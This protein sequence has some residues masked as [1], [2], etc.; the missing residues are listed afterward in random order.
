MISA[1]RTGLA[2]ALRSLKVRVT[3]GVVVALVVGIGTIAT[4]LVNRAE[5]DTLRD[6]RQRELSDAAR[7]ADQVSNNVVGLQR[8]LEA[9]ARRLDAATLADP[10]EL[11][12]LIRERPLLLLRF[13]SVFVTGRDGQVRVLADASGVQH[14]VLN[15]AD[16][17]YFRRTLTERRPIVSEPIT[18]RVNGQLI[19]ILTYPVTGANGI[20]AVLSGSLRLSSRDLLSGLMDVQESDVDALTVLTDAEGRV[21][22]HPDRARVMHSLADEPR[23]AAA[24]AAWVAQGSPM[25]PT[26]VAL[27]QPGEMVSAA[28]AAGTNWMAWR[29]RSESELLAPLRAARREAVVWAAGLIALIS[30]AMFVFLWRELR[31]LVLLERRAQHLFDGQ[32]DADAAW[33]DAGGEIGRLGRVLR[34]VGAERAQ[35][36]AFNTQVLRKLGSVMSAA[37]IGIA[38]TR[39]KRFELVSAEF[40]RLFGRTEPELLGQPAR[41]IYADDAD[42][43]RLAPRVG[44]AFAAGQAY[45]GEW[46]MRR[47]D[48][49]T[50]WASLRGNPVEPGDYAAGTIWSIA[51]ISDQRVENEQLAWLAMHDSLTGLANRKLL[52][53]RA[54]AVVAAVPRSVPGA[55]IFIDLDRFK[56]INDTAGHAAGDAMLRA[57]AEALLATVRASDL[58]V[59]LG[60]DEFALLLERCGEDVAVRIAQSVRVAID[61]IAL[62][63]EGRTLRVGA[64]LGVACLQA[65]TASVDAW[66]AAADAACYA[67]KGAGRGAVRVHDPRDPHDHTAPACAEA[68]G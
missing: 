32:S 56:P 28:G 59:R 27:P 61:A 38:F 6:Q 58:V 62:D 37:P 8:D 46:Q 26:G 9:V 47:A 44:E 16:R 57:V 45:A 67:A 11:D 22:A 23:L 25:E 2:Y 65:D 40:C 15:V 21:L 39:D 64:S 5:H 51:D 29:A 19:I 12:R 54:G 14:P 17:S 41:M 3:L 4:A 10:S 55:L 66:I 7:T 48:G 53:Q 13:S 52:H 20:A 31:P 36:E 42:H 18:S 30:I 50:F 43:D 60:G 68:P 24:F 34:H 63:W 49:T 33:P 1:A 35:L